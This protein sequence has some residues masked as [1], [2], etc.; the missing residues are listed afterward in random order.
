MLP[1]SQARLAFSAAV[2]DG[3][4]PNAGGALCFRSLAACLTNGST[5]CNLYSPCSLSPDL[6]ATGEAAGTRGLYS[7]R[8]PLSLGRALARESGALRRSPCVQG[9]PRRPAQWLQA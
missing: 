6:C 7:W 9:L 3:G 2:G 4:V 5:A 8:A 1:V